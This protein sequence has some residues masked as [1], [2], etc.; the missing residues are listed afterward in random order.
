MLLKIGDCAAFPAATV[1]GCPIL[2]NLIC[3]GSNLNFIINCGS[4]TTTWL[5]SLSEQEKL[6]NDNASKVK[7]LILIFFLL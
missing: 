4:Y 6:T 5:S 7:I 1:D 2:F 3:V